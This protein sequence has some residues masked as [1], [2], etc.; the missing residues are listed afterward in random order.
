MRCEILK[1]KGDWNEVLN[2]CR[3]TVGKDEIGSYPSIEWRRNL[4]LSEHSPIRLIHVHAKFY[5][6]PYW[7]SVHL[8][9]HSVGVH[10]PD[11]EPLVQTERSDRTGIPRDD[12]PQGNLVNMEL[13]A[14]L[15]AIIN[16]SRKR[17]CNGASPETQ[18][19]WQK[20]LSALNGYMPEI[21]DICVPE[22]I[23]RGFCPEIY[24]CGW[25]KQDSYVAVLNKYRSYL[26]R[27]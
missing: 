16:M 19:A 7:V 6:I 5:D 1:I 3:T 20:F 24:S 18:E 27:K 12:L 17:L 2:A 4:L 25:D 11:Y 14:N 21:S 15:M 23:Y 13:E 10:H 9:R 26:S 22:C 8:L